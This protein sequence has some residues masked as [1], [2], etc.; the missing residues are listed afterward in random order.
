M[1]IGNLQSNLDQ[2][3]KEVKAI[4]YPTALDEEA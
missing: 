4:N 2:L 3:R 1:S